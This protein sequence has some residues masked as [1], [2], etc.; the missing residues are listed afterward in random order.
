MWALNGAPIQNTEAL[1]LLDR[2]KQRSGFQSSLWLL[3]RHLT[4]FNVRP[5]YPPQVMLP[6]C[7]LL[8]RPPCA[9]PFSLLRPSAQ[10]GIL[11]D[12]PPP[13]V[14]PGRFLFIER[15]PAG[16]R[17]RTATLAECFEA[18]FAQG[19]S[20]YGHARL[21]CEPNFTELSAV[22]GEVGVLNAQE[23]SN[24]FLVDCS[25]CH[26]S[27]M[28]GAAFE[29]SVSSALTTIAAQFRYTSFNWVEASVVETSGLRVR[30]SAVPHLVNSAGVLRVVHVSQLPLSRQE[31]L[32]DSVPRRVMLK[33]MRTSFVLLHGHWRPEFALELTQRL[34]IADIPP[35]DE[36]EA[37][38]MPLLLWVAV[39]PAEAFS[40]EVTERER[41][42]HRRF[43]NAQQLE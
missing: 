15:N 41:S 27:L 5:L 12:F 37:R 33:S 3:P 2:Y 42:I 4:L 25:L 16:T 14:P 22:P 23:T 11:G 1:Q 9:V 6:V 7:S 32:V 43:Y 40:G 35:V 39:T 38:A 36:G 29:D 17:W 24:P 20:S 21:L 19:G 10:R 18:A 28:T 8:P 30:P 13:T 26:R 34:R 31:L